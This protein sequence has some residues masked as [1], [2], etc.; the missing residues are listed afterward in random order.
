[1]REYG[2]WAA[3]TP[4][5]PKLLMALDNGVG[6]GSP[7]MI[8]WAATTFASAEVA[9]IGPAGHH[10]PEDRPDEIGRA[11]ADWLDRHALVGA[12]ARS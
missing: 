9:P 12:A 10:A 4:E 11:V 2:A 1:M 8:D 6:L 7:E 5:V 3:A